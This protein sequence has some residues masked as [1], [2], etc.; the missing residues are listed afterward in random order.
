MK[1]GRPRL[2][3]DDRSVTINFRIPSKRFDAL[4]REALRL[5]VTLPELI[6]HK[7]RLTDQRTKSNRNSGG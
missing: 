2:D 4:C 1:A 5:Q 3:P 6:R 7:I